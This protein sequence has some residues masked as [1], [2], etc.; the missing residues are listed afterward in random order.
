MAKITTFTMC[1]NAVPTAQRY[2]DKE[3][4]N[5]PLIYP[6]PSILTR[7][8]NEKDMPAT[9]EAARTRSITKIKALIYPPPSILTRCYNER[10]MP[11][12]HE[13]ARTRNITEIKSEN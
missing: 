5:H 1:A 4:K 12:T 10:D 8:Y 2:L 3:I 9:Y 7:C 11:A 6:P 13:A